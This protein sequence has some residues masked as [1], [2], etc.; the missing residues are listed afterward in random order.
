MESIKDNLNERSGSC[1]LIA[2]IIDDMLYISNCGN[3][4]AILSMNEGKNIKVLNKIHGISNKN[5]IKRV[6]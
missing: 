4:Y 3:S 2:L 1:A 5:E 6:E